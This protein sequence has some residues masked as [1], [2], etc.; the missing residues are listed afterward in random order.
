M[1]WSRPLKLI[2]LDKSLAGTREKKNYENWSFVIAAGN[3]L[4]FGLPYDPFFYNN[5]RIPQLDRIPWSDF[6]ND[7]LCN[8]DP[9]HLVLKKTFEERKDN[10]I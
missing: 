7:I 3:R 5:C 1:F 9:H 4:G 2:K 10:K 6:G 8:K